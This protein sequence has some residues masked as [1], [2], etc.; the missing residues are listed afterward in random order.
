MSDA[1]CP[2][3]EGPLELE[4]VQKSPSSYNKTDKGQALSCELCEYTTKE[5]ERIE[6]FKEEM[7]KLYEDRGLSEMLPDK[8]KEYIDF[9]A[10]KTL[11][12]LLI[13]CKTHHISLEG[14][15]EEMHQGLDPVNDTGQIVTGSN[16]EVVD[17]DLEEI[18]MRGEK[19]IKL[20]LSKEHS[21]VPRKLVEHELTN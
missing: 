9:I 3:C 1:E 20:G 18:A 8:D 6:A 12:E 17:L 19:R 13:I 5:R 2:E 15:I 21:E 14:L 4:S 7:E 10:R 11:R 16:D